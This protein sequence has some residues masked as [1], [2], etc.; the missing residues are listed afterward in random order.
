ML[1]F[2]H[3]GMS[4]TLWPHGLQHTRPPC[5][6]PSLR[7]CPSLCPLSQWC[8]S[9]IS[10]SITPFSSC[11]QSFPA[12]VSFPMSQFFTSGAQSIGISAS[13]SVLPINIQ[14]WFPLGSTGLISLLSKE[15]FRQHSLK[16]LVLHCSAFLMGQLSHTYM[17][18]GKTVALTIW[19]FVHKVMSLLFNTLSRFVIAVMKWVVCKTALRFKSHSPHYGSNVS[20]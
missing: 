15:L 20:L 5:P 12:S 9:T 11:P 10:S 8:H 1:F 16:A 13:A 4:G 17:T 2:S 14:N 3:Q 6:S 7:V 19:T 18:T